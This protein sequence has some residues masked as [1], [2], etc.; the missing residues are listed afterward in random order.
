MIEDERVSHV[1]ELLFDYV[2]SPSLKHIRDPYSIIK[3]AQNIVR[4][5][6]RSSSIWKKW[7]GPREL[8]LQSAL[9]CW[10]PVEDLRDFLNRMP[11]PPLT[12]TDVAQRL[13]AF[14]EEEYSWY[15]KDEMKAGCLAIYAKE[16]AEG[17]ELSAIVQLLRDHIEREEERLR[18][19]FEERYRQT[20]EEE[21]V[22]RERRLLS[23]ADCTWTQVQKSP[24]WY[25]RMNGRTYRLSPSKD[26]MWTL[27]RVNAVKDD[28]EG[29]Y[30]G[31]YQRRGNATKVV[32]EMAYKPEPTW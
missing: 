15:P 25:C 1:K 23:G 22:A 10:I 11:G 21:R 31:Q 7:D 19:E 6:D 27:Y 5:L 20:R 12:T 14:E 2:K 8:L 9:P 32:A 13:R 24:H 29:S 4:R 16:K 28:E 3:L 18:I 30:I 17:T 26:K